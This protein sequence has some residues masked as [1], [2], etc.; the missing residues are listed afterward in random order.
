MMVSLLFNVS[1]HIRSVY[2]VLPSLFFLSL[3]TIDT[4][5]AFAASLQEE[6][7]AAQATE[8]T[9]RALAAALME[10]EEEVCI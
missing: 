7:A 6:E 2:K 10:E 1:Y 3:E 8:E 4:D 5:L 9:D